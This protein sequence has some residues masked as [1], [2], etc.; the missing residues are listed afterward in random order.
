MMTPNPSSFESER[1][2]GGRL[3]EGGAAA[4]WLMLRREQSNAAS[5]AFGNQLYYARQGK[6]T[7]VEIALNYR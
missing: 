2:A 5:V 3:P 1:L 6:K 4:C 7:Q